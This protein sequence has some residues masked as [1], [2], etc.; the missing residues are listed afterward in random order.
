[1]PVEVTY[2]G[3]YVQELPSGTRTITG[4]ATAI[5]AFIGR[6][7]FG[8]VDEATPI[9]NFDDFER[10]F[11][12][13]S[14][15]MTLGYAVRDFFLNGG[16]QALIV[17]LYREPAM[18]ADAG[19]VLEVDGLKLVAASPGTWGKRLR[20][21]IGTNVLPAARSQYGLG[22]KDA[23]FDLA[24]SSDGASESFRNLTVTDTP[25]R[26]DR[27][28][29]TQSRLVRWASSV[30]PDETNAPMPLFAALVTAKQAFADAL[31]VTLQIPADVAEAKTGVDNALFLLCDPATQAEAHLKSATAVN[32]PAA[33][34]T[35]DTELQSAMAA[36]KGDDGLPLIAATYGGDEADHTG[37]HALDQVDLFNLLCIPPEARGASLDPAIYRQAADYCGKRR[38]ML[39]VDAPFE[40]SANPN[41][42][43][44]KATLGLATLGLTGDAARNA[45]L[46]FPALLEPDP[47][48]NGQPGTFAPC[49]AVAGLYAHTD[50]TRGVW[51]AP[52]GTSAGIAG[53]LG[54]QLTLSD[55]AAEM[56]NPLGINCIR[57][58]PAIGTVVWGARTLA[59]ADGVGDTYKYVPVRRTALYIEES[60]YRGLKWTVLEPNDEP[61]WA[62]IR[63]SV[64]AFMQGL[65]KQGAFQGQSAAQGYF[66]KC[67]HETTPQADIDQGII[68]LFV[69]FAPLKPAEFV[70]VNLR[71]LTR[72]PQV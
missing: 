60:L 24:L 35:A 31:A 41:D 47:L 66:V 68:N 9:Y 46:Y 26:I 19:S 42:A 36:M 3:V 48:R 55:G 70:V 22:D 58:F 10:I 16:E 53:A 63:L 52:A 21:S 49:G 32:D 20:A 4:V 64:G 37:L 18:P 72:Q 5:T 62:R 43:L 14:K 57:A 13:L 39:L 71:Q 11:G 25:R 65:F 40:W 6:A 51:K 38:A 69:G 15:D 27:V 2:P 23:L 1:M 61:L 30:P 17:R 28:L 29:A 45:A 50:S 59:G 8:P 33:I 56:L 67:D 54:P 44:G 12:G 7:V 34:A